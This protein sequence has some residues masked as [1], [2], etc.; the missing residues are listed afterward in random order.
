MAAC[1]LPPAT[2]RQ[3]PK[4]SNI[5][6]LEPVA[7]NRRTHYVPRPGLNCRAPARGEHARTVRIIR[8]CAAHSTLA[9]P[10]AAGSTDALLLRSLSIS[11]AP[12][13]SEIT[14]MSHIC[15][16]RDRRRDTCDG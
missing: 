4:Q 11:H 6:P 5:A 8:T 16:A 7:R 9:T 15:H 1:Y 10:I 14:Q 13:H 3:S 2:T 12:F